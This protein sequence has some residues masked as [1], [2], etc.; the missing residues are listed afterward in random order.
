[1]RCTPREINCENDSGK[2]EIRKTEYEKQN[3]THLFSARAFL[4][5]IHFSSLRGCKRF[6]FFFNLLFS[7][8]C[9]LCS[10]SLVSSTDFQSETEK[11]AFA[12]QAAYNPALS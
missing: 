4:F 10:M 8:F 11:L 3:L 7:H 12:Y 5:R 1:M 9:S 6:F 2:I